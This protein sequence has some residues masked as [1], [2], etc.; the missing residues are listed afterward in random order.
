MKAEVRFQVSPIDASA[1]LLS[2]VAARFQS[3]SQSTVCLSIFLG[4]VF[5]AHDMIRM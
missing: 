5:A 1:L 3:L 2:I 4:L